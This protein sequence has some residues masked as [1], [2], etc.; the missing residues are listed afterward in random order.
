MSSNLKWPHIC[1]GLVKKIICNR[2]KKKKTHLPVNTTQCLVDYSLF[3]VCLFLEQLS[4]LRMTNYPKQHF[5]LRL[6]L[7]QRKVVDL[8]I[9]MN[10]GACSRTIWNLVNDYIRQNHNYS[11]CQLECTQASN[12]KHSLSIKLFLETKN[13][14]KPKNVI[15]TWNCLQELTAVPLTNCHK[16]KCTYSRGGWGLNTNG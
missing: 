10:G 12:Q 3:F 5:R 6:S 1:S 8:D 2:K 11:Y 16:V 9:W 14:L 4:G 7:G 15:Q 13:T